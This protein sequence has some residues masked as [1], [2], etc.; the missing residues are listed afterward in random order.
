VYKAAL[1]VAALWSVYLMIF[2][3]IF[4]ISYNYCTRVANEHWPCDAPDYI[5]CQRV[6]TILFTGLWLIIIPLAALCFFILVPAAVL[7]CMR[8][9]K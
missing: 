4:A 1:V 8:R 5:T 9:N 3:A 6:D 7:S 2:T